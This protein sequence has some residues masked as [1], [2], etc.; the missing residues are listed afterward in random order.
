[1]SIT[2]GTIVLV[3]VFLV[4]A[5]AINYM[6]KLNMSFNSRVISALVIGIVFGAIIQY[7]VKDRETITSAMNWI[8]L[9]GSGYVRLL[10]MIVYPLILVSITKSIA[11]QEK[12]VGKSA[13]R[14]L[15]VLVV[16]VAIAAFVGAITSSVFG[17]SAEGLQSSES[18]EKRGAAMLEKM[19]T[20]EQVP[21]Q[22]QILE[23][24]PTNPFYALTG[25]GNN[26]TLATVF[27]A[28]MI[29]FSTL[30]LRRAQSK[31]ADVF[32][33]FLNAFSD[34]IMR[35]VKIVLRLTPYGV[36][37][38]MTNV[39][40]T[41]NISDVVRLLNFILASY[42]AIIIMFI[43]HAAI[44]ALNGL[45]PIKFYKKSLSNL[46]FAF[47]SRSS[48][49]ALPITITNMEQNLGVPTGIA[50]LAG[51]LG[52]S[53]GQ[54]GCAGIYPAML[55]VMIAPTVGIN[56]LAPAFLIKLIIVTALGSFGIVGVGGGATFAAIVVLSTM[57]LPIDLAGLLIAIEPLIDMGRTA[58]NVSD[59]IV[60]GVVAAKRGGELNEE[61]YNSNEIV[62]E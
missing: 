19:E 27:F 43:V 59:S 4:L 35:M 3:A 9:V 25:Q 36:M 52:T 48:S 18:T 11:T 61:I 39:T 15:T 2:M 45:N 46:M 31:S 44:I 53:I 24:I 26:A 56:A 23:I 17:L 62:T 7:F 16:T 42:V 50:N 13:A 29:G 41:S 14:I 54:N 8:T 30:Y 60:A 6:K 20:F 57:G 40:A 49:G 55:A 58:L 51:S 5:L 34:V 10:R 47:T 22:Q 12:N 37:A 28:A 21:V 33:E 1:M 32:I 38:L